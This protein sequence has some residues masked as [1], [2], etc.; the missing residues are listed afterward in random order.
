MTRIYNRNELKDS[1]KELRN[2]CTK[3]EAKL[4]KYLRKSRLEDYKFRRQ[5]SIDSYIIDFY[6]PEKNLAIELDGQYHLNPK[7]KEYDIERTK[8]LDQLNIQVIRF[9]NEDVL[10]NIEQVLCEIEK[11]LNHPP[12]PLLN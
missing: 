11:H 10:N 2:N 12:P 9:K 5:Q 4:W 6:C 7:Q 1:R 3:A 8:I